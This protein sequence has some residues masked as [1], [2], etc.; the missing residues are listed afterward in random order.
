[1]IKNLIKLA[2][3]L[4]K[5]GLHKEADYVDWII[6]T[7]S[8]INVGQLNKKATFLPVGDVDSFINEVKEV[9]SKVEDLFSI[10]FTGFKGKVKPPFNNKRIYAQ[11]YLLEDVEYYLKEKMH[12][13]GTREQ[14]MMIR[15]LKEKLQAKG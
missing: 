6:K 5:K 13:G 8:E 4:D 2:D 9:E 1:M 14:F 15:K 12:N 11:D 3:H 10:A 7:Q